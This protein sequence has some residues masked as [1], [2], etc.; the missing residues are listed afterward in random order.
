MI[1]FSSNRRWLID[2]YNDTVL[3][4]TQ[5]WYTAPDGNKVTIDD[6]DLRAGSIMYSNPL[7]AGDIPCRPSPTLIKVVNG[8]SIDTGLELARQDLNPV[9]LNFANRH[10]PGG[11]V[12][13]GARAQ[14]ECIFR[15]TNLFRSLYQFTPFAARYGLEQKRPQY[16]MNQNFGGVY[17]PGASV[18]K[19]S[20]YEPLKVP[21]QLSFISV[22]AINRP[23]LIN[24]EIAPDYVEI[25]LNKMRTILRIGLINGHDSI[26]LGAFGCGAFSNPPH[27]IARLFKKVLDEDEFKNKYKVVVFAIME[28]HNSRNRNLQPFLTTFPT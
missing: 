11:G 14:E 4:A 24:G 22:A 21:E 2:V 7:S 3:T 27:H 10:H 16:P 25:T 9:V 5:G 8:D 18:F 1:D 19:S 28:D 20:R 17:S 13:N 23:D 12:E 26:V 6:T 15:R